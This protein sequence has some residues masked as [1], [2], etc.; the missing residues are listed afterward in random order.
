MSI[1]Q[2]SNQDVNYNQ[3]VVFPSAQ[4]ISAAS[5]PLPAGAATSAKQPALGVAG[6]PSADV[7]SVQGIAGGTAIPVTQAQAASAALTSVLAAVISTSILAS[8]VNR[9]GYMLFNDGLGVCKVAFAATASATAFSILL[10]PNTGYEP[11]TMYTGAISAIWSSASGSM[12][13]TEF[14]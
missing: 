6:T 4:P 12:R 2:S 13:V 10:A 3:S 1:L 11:G 9:K 7:I 14:S 8:N 5:L